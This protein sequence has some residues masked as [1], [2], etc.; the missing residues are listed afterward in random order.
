MVKNV[1]NDYEKFKQLML[2]EEFKICIVE[3]IKIHIDERKT[4]TTYKLVILVD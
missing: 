3:D 4:E 2:V 1:E